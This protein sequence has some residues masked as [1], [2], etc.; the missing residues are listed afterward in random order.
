MEEEVW[1][2]RIRSLAEP[3][4][5]AEYEVFEAEAYVKR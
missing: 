3:I 2:H 1:M 5:K 4:Q